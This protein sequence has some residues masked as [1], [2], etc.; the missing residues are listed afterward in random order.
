MLKWT[1]ISTGK[2]IALIVATF[3]A[4]NVFLSQTI[5]RAT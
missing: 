3:V 2:L 4:I 1:S 5:G